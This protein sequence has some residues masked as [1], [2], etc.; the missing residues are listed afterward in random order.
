MGT[1]SC[2]II[3]VNFNTLD[4]LMKCL[5]SVF[6]AQEA[7]RCEVIVVDNASADGSAAMV[8]KEFRSVKL[9]ENTSNLGFSK[10]NNQGIAAS[11]GRYILLLN[12]DTEV[13]PDS[14]TKMVAFLDDNSEAGIVGP[15]VL[16]PDLTYQA[17]GRNFPE[18]INTFFGRKS[19]LTRL[20][21]NN[22]FSREYMTCLDRH[23][24]DLDYYE[25]DWVSGACLMIRRS[26]LDEVG[27]LDEGFF[28]YWEDV[29]LCFRVKKRG[30][31]VYYLNSAVIVHHEGKSRNRKNIL[32]KNRL[33]KEFY[34]GAYRYYCKHKAPSRLQPMRYVAFAGI[35]AKA[36]TVLLIDNVKYFAWQKWATE[37]VG[38]RPR[39]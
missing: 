35:C 7:D 24:T 5:K 15:R 8:K 25:V 36:T 13:Y 20:F 39:P 21:P 19:V 3:I 11:I 22:R 9:I 29:D 27:T 37:T 16:N 10:A 1:P 12:S 31:L 32:L 17:T 6:I 26:V 18:P 30:W 38:K 23:K 34:R 14:I 28:F 2:S 4:L 33:I